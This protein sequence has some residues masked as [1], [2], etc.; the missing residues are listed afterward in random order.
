M[1]ELTNAS[2]HLDMEEDS[3][4]GTIKTF[5]MSQIHV[6]CGNSVEG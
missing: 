5:P 6:N 2:V 3:E 1:L 4:V